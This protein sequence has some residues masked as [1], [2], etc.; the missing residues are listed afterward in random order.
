METGTNGQTAKGQKA[1]PVTQRIGEAGQYGFR[2]AYKYR[3]R[4]DDSVRIGRPISE[5]QN[6][7]KAEHQAGICYSAEITC[8]GT[9]REKDNPKCENIGCQVIS[10]QVTTERWKKLQ[11]YSY[12]PWCVKTSF[13]D[14]GG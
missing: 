9:F 8:K 3:G 2:L 11:F 13:S 6:R 7:S 5:N 4:T 1:M 14:G 10:Y 12:H